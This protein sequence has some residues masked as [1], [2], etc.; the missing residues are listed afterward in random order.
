ML[1]RLSSLSDSD[2]D[3]F[4]DVELP[5]T[6][7]LRPIPRLI[8]SSRIYF[9][10]NGY[11]EFGI[12]PSIE[13]GHVILSSRALIVAGLSW[14]ILDEEEAANLFIFLRNKKK[15]SN[16]SGEDYYHDFI[17]NDFKGTFLLRKETTNQ[18]QLF[19]MDEK[20]EVSGVYLERD[21]IV[22]ML[23]NEKIINNQILRSTLS[24]DDV[25]EKLNIFAIYCDGSAEKIRIMASNIH[26]DGLSVEMATNHY[27]FFNEFIARREI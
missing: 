22:N 23:V 20:E 21:A 1:Q 11:I 4:D 8:N 24:C 9:P 10:M 17:A 15:F 6:V 2:F 14:M 7:Q 12:L 19:F 26:S 18:Y 16:V 5:R 3:D 27:D 25:M 13:D